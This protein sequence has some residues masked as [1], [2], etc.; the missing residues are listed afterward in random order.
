LT[1]QKKPAVWLTGHEATPAVE[2]YSP[3]TG[4]FAPLQDAWVTSR[5]AEDGEA[6]CVEVHTDGDAWTCEL[7]EE[8]EVR[9]P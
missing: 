1:E 5:Y 4:E 7:D 2:V 3:N 6:P 9:V 8:V